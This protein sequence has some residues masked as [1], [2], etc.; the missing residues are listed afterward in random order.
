M[1]NVQEYNDMPDT[2][3]AAQLNL[4]KEMKKKVLAKFFAILFLKQRNQNN[5]LNLLKEFRQ[6]YANDQRD[7]FPKDLTSM[8]DVMRMVEFDK[9]KR[10]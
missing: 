8:F 1:E 9:R 5:Y 6:S 10:S 3:A 7:L 4:Q 2:D